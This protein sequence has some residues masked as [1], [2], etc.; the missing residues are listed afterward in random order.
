MMRMS[1]NK[2]ITFLAGI[3]LGIGL[4]MIFAPKSGEEN[5][6]YIAKK[7]NELI[8][9]LKET[10]YNEIKDNLVDRI[11]NLQEELAN[12][13]KEKVLKLA[14]IKAEQIKNKAE[15]IYKEAVKKGKPVLEK[16][17][18]ELKEK[19]VIV[20]KDTIAR[21]EQDTSNKKTTVKKTNKKNTSV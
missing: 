7:A 20:L 10:D 6:K 12:L 2:G 5:R 17:A 11:E 13:D 21:L 1:K 8:K 16:T 4:G 18:K 3:G 15:E 19:T 9:K 14:S